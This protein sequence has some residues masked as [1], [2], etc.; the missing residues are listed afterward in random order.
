MSVGEKTESRRVRGFVQASR[1]WYFRAA[2]PS[3]REEFTIGVYFV[4]PNDG[5]EGELSVRMTD[6]GAWRLEAFPDAWKLLGT[7]FSDL[8]AWLA[9]VQKDAT[10]DH[11]RNG[12][13]E[14]GI[15]DLTAADPPAGTPP[16]RCRE[17]SQIIPVQNLPAAQAEAESAGQCSKEPR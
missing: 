5:C 8:L 1:S 14:I 7:E 13:L 3:G 10:A 17:C 6:I 12:L 16:L 2:H 9:T 4:E 11:I 15:E